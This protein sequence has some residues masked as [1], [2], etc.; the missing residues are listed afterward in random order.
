[1]KRL[2]PL[3]CIPCPVWGSL[4]QKRHLILEGGWWSLLSWLGLEL[5]FLELEDGRGSGN[6]FALNCRSWKGSFLLPLHP[7]TSTGIGVMPRVGT[8]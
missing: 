7:Q 4:V 8:S 1:M 2:Y 5:G 6:L 3:L